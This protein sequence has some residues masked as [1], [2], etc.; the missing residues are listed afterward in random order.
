MGA[1]GASK[2]AATMIRAG[3]GLEL[4]HHGIRVNVVAPGSTDTDMQR[5]LWPDPAD[6][7]GAAVRSRQ[8]RGFQGGNPAGAHRRRRR[9]RRLGRV[10]PV[11]AR[12]SH[13]DAGTLRRRRRDAAGLTPVAALPTLA[14]H[15]KGARREYA[16]RR[17][18]LVP[19]RRIPPSSRSATG[20]PDTGP[21][22]P[23]PASCPPVPSSSG[24]AS[25]SPARVRATPCAPSRTVS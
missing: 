22:R 7:T 25:P 10:P 11:R 14:H 5:S 4:A 12:P 13:H 6:D 17:S 21:T 3:H 20:T 1:Y 16:L 9:Y 15:P 18:P 19:P 23:S 2:A 8:S 24:T